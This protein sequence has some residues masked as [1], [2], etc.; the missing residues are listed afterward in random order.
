MKKFVVACL[1]FALAL[2]ASL[3]AHLPANATASTDFISVW[4]TR[5]TST[6]SSDAN[7]LALPL[8]SDGL[9][10]FTVNWGDNS[11]STI[12]AYNDSAVTHTYAT[13]GTYT[14]T[15]SGTIDGFAFQDGGDKLKLI[16]ISNWGSLK[17][18]N[19]EG[20]FQGA[21]NF[22]SSANDAPDL[23]ATTTLKN[24]FQGATSFNGA[25]DNWDVSGVTNLESAFDNATSF[26]KPLN[27]WD[28][29]NVTEMRSVFYGASA[30]N[31][32]LSN[33]N[34]SKVW[35]F[36]IMFSGASAFNQSLGSW[37]IASGG[38]AAN[39]ETQLD[40][41]LLDTALSSE[42][43]GL[44][45]LGWS[46]LPNI[47]SMHLNG[48]GDNAPNSFATNARYSSDAPV[49][50][51]REALVANGWN[52]TDGGP[53]LIRVGQSHVVTATYTNGTN[54]AVTQTFNS[55]T[56]DGDSSQDFQI[57][58]SATTCL[59]TIN[60]G[61]SCQIGLI[62]TPSFEGHREAHLHLHE[63]GNPQSLFSQA[64]V[65]EIAEGDCE[66]Q[67]TQ[68]S[69]VQND[70]YLISTLDQLN[71][72][73][74]VDSAGTSTHLGAAY[75]LVSDLNLG[76]DDAAFNP[77][78]TWNHEFSGIFDGNGH[79]VTNMTTSGLW[80]G[81]MPWPKSAIIKNLTFTNANVTSEN[82]GGVL[83]SY[84]DG[85]TVIENV[86]VVGGTLTGTR[87]GVYGGLAAYVTG[88]T[89]SNS[90]ATAAIHIDALNAWAGG[91]VGQLDGSSNFVEKSY[92]GGSIDY[93]GVGTPEWAAFGGLVGGMNATSLGSSIVNCYTTTDINSSLNG[94]ITTLG[95]LIGNL[96]AGTVNNSLALGSISAAQNNV[97][98][99][100]VGYA[101]ADDTLFTL[102]GNFWDTGITGLA[103]D[104]LV[105]DGELVGL[106]S[107]DLSTLATFTSA[108][109]D[110]SRTWDASK[111]WFAPQGSYP[112]LSWE[113]DSAF[114]A[115]ANPGDFG[116]SDGSSGNGGSGGSNG[117][118]GSGTDSNSGSGVGVSANIRMSAGIGQPIAGTTT[119]FVANGLQ[120]SAPFD[121]VVRS[122]PQTLATGN[123]VAGSVNTT[124][125]MPGGLDAGWHSLTF[126]STASDG[127]AFTQV[128][129][130]RLS[131]SGL[132]LE[133]STTMPAD[134]AFTGSNTMGYLGFALGLFVVGLVAIAMRRVLNVR[135][136]PTQPQVLSGD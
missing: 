79:T 40:E 100:F 98:N 5:N 65:D 21:A 122:T 44:T 99:G 112:V 92:S 11:S 32:S 69:G 38:I 126:S 54:P 89:I 77:L 73:T 58:L 66:S 60:P 14:I 4:D 115:A 124:V 125:T 76:S 28:V 135:R 128:L 49:L 17:L 18:G 74:A 45:L 119:T 25:I 81:F 57:D 70:P 114:N 50:A 34:V 110:I 9:Y 106:N 82:D 86:H 22:N 12:T 96:S 27:S 29:S 62:F 95:G 83:S 94:S 91:L 48:A 71:C 104:T 24:A 132:L 53:A 87:S 107:T 26:N 30:F 2:G 36:G 8:R 23:T 10:N 130:F 47:N 31:Q 72:I 80:A 55:I 108:S 102:S 41:M 131:D 61:A 121:I 35:H 118:S 85:G 117:N 19:S 59:A 64:T 52:I 63:Q 105:A 7:S 90:S 37:D 111:A 42:N 84:V 56:L 109:W 133:T 101:E 67:F 15:I 113:G 3:S 51:A 75:Q 68:G 123:A 120:Q 97:V 88:A 16:D 33:W 39:R 1:T 6:G 127:S 20:Y 129:Y 46:Q 134:L 116:S 103:T 78:G 43:Y 93:V 13:P 136:Q